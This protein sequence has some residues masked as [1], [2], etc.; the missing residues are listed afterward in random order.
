MIVSKSLYFY[1]A[2]TH[3]FVADGTRMPFLATKL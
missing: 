2:Q 3:E 1:R